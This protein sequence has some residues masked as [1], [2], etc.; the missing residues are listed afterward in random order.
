MGGYL[1]GINIVER[2]IGLKLSTIKE[3][4]HAA[5]LGKNAISNAFIHC[6]KNALAS[7]KINKLIEALQAANKS[8][9]L[10]ET[11]TLIKSGHTSGSDIAAGILHGVV[12][13]MNEN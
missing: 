12:G 13:G 2:L 8:K 3:E 11:K 1:L 10:R 7:E 6:S 5:A 4:I 9:I